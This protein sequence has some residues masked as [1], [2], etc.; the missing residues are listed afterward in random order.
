MTETH[1]AL[2][3]MELD[4]AYASIRALIDTTNNGKLMLVNIPMPMRK[5]VDE[6]VLSNHLSRATFIHPGDAVRVGTD[7]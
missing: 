6:L 4:T 5:H 1:P 2:R 3:T 7:L